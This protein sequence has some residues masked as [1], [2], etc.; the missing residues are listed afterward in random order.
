MYTATELFLLI[1]ITI[2]LR[3]LTTKLSPKRDNSLP[4][5]D[6][7]HRPYW[8]G[9]EMLAGLL[10]DQEEKPE[11]CGMGLSGQM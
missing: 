4:E 1:N 9:A 7:K 3:N 8:Q 6:I 2:G 5:E 10:S 11:H